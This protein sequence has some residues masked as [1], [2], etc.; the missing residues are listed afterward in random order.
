MAGKTIK[1][2]YVKSFMSLQL[3]MCQIEAFPHLYPISKVTFF[4]KVISPYLDSQQ[5][6]DG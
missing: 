1:L 6:L 3:F 2:K 4:F 5:D